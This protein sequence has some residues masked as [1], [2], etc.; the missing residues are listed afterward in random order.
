MKKI[1]LH[2]PAL[3]RPSVTLDSTHKFYD[4]GKMKKSNAVMK[5]K[6]CHAVAVKKNPDG[7]FDVTYRK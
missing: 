1:H 3:Q 5:R 6:D 7:S 2:L 4:E